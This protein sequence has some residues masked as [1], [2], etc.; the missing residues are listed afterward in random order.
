M[1]S[2][3]G[4]SGSGNGNGLGMGRYYGLAASTTTELI[5]NSTYDAPIVKIQRE[6][7]QLVTEDT[8]T[9][10]SNSGLSKLIQQRQK[11]LDELVN[12]K[13]LKLKGKSG[14]ASDSSKLREFRRHLLNY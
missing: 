12:A 6:I 9:G 1:M 10:N 8:K 5:D 2:S 14:A 3:T 11:D 7:S 13:K 4:S